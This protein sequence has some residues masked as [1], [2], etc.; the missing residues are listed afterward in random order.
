[1]GEFLD[2]DMVLGAF[3]DRRT[4]SHA[5]SFGSVLLLG[6]AGLYAAFKAL[7]FLEY[8]VWL[9]LYMAFEK[10][11]GLTLLGGSSTEA[12][13]ADDNTK[14]Q[15]SGNLLSR[16]FGVNG[17]SLLQ[18]GVR[19]VAGALSN[20]PSDV[21]PGLGNWDNSCY[22]NSVI[23][24]LAS[25]PSL[26][27][28]LSRATAEYRNL[29]TETTNGA[30][31]DMVKKLNDPSNH[32]QNFW[33]RGKLKSMSTF[34]QQDAQEYYSK[35]L[36][37][38]DKEVQQEAKKR[39]PSDAWADAAKV[40]AKELEGIPDESMDSEEPDA[41][42]DIGQAKAISNP[43]DGLLAQ[44]VG[45]I[46]CGYV[47]GL[48]LIPFNCVTVSL[49]RDSTY[50]IRECL[51]DY[52]NLEQ[53]EGVECAK[54]TLL[55]NKDALTP[56]AERAPAYAE[57]LKEVEDALE[58]DDFD[59]KTLVKKFKILKKNWTQSTKS[60]QAVIA[61]APKALVLHVNR[62]IFDEMTGAMYKNSAK[63]S[64][65]R[66]LD[67]GNWCLGSDVAGGEWPRDP[68]KSM[69][70][71]A[72]AEPLT[73]SP[74]QYR[75]R[76]AVTHYGS[77]ANG[78]YVCYRPHAKT[79]TSNTETDTTEVAVTGEQWWRFS[80]DSV[81]SIPEQQAHQGN[82]FMLF[83]ERI[84]DDAPVLYDTAIASCTFSAM[85][86]DIP[87]PPIDSLAHAPAD[88]VAT[89]VPLPD[90]DDDLLEEE[91]AVNASDD[92]R[93]ASGSVTPPRGSTAESETLA[94]QVISPPSPK[95]SEPG[96]SAYPTPPPEF[97]SAGPMD[98]PE[99]SETASEDASSTSLTS[100]DKPDADQTT[101]TRQQ[102]KAAPSPHF[103]RTA[104]TSANREGG[105]RTSLPMVTA[106]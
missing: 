62:S 73:H 104:G 6:V 74:Y 48:Q 77:H 39:R 52:T 83:Y 93:P 65:P 3:N 75:L 31:Y 13:S 70:G 92:A 76:A 99:M 23:Q 11:R 22:Q 37:A 64:Y 30:L 25:L 96:I 1:M 87:L 36:D 63:V 100:D 20:A 88:D 105:S 24:G 21:P 44:R 19:G 80:D 82:I 84:D 26:R 68:T 55:R 51:D 46:K 106:T 33:I 10:A 71:D 102:A 57:R 90:E 8:P 69:L 79:P 9:W 5:S 50:D 89:T 78:H 95:A 29:D 54:C 28:Y 101:K 35:I 42:H 98:D 45:C 72:T 27:E 34:Q 17:S 49:G 7:E 91:P 66:V 16:T 85:E 41:E 86:D 47:E 60:R 2:D 32:G 94:T 40:V 12:P 38:M 15:N 97:P 43:L 53:I 14:M 58:N 61:R 67:L 81:Y 4:E 103:M 59:D 56:L 18:K